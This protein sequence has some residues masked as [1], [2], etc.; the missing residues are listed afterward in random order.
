MLKKWLEDK[1]IITQRQEDQLSPTALYEEYRKYMNEQQYNELTMKK[2]CMEMS[3]YLPKR[4]SGAGM[5]YI[6]IKL[7]KS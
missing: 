4:R 6:G 2:F 1:C 7:K 3:Q 5:L